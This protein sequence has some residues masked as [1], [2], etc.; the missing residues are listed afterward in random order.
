VQEETRPLAEKKPRPYPIAALELGLQLFNHNY[1]FVKLSTNNL[2]SFKAGIQAAPALRAEFYP[3]AFADLGLASGIGLDAQAAMSFGFKI[4]DERDNK[5]PMRWSLMDGGLRWR[6]QFS[7]TW[8]AAVTPMVGLQ[9]VRLSHGALE[10]GATLNG[11]PKLN[12]TAL[13]LGLGFELPL[14]SEWFVVFGDFSYVP[15]LS[16]KEILAA[17]Y[18]PEGSAFGLEGKLGVNVKMWGPLF[19]R[20][21]G[22]L[23]RTNFT[24]KAESGSTYVADSA[25]YQRMGVQL[26]FVAAF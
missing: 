13:R 17:P 7:R 22:F 11:F 16:A 23:S 1:E 25:R 3:L 14:V 12:I 9:N 8:K 24:L 18:F 10:D 5:F 19:V 4:K 15:V 6:M 26:G 21:T 20:F 2:R